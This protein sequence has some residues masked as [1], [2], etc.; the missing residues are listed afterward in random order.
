MSGQL[1]C[2][3]MGWCFDGNNGPYCLKLQGLAMAWTR[4]TNGMT[5]VWH[6]PPATSTVGIHI[7]TPSMTQKTGT[8][9]HCQQYG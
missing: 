7:R 8:H 3:A 2:D 4:W 6:T 5:S 1:Y 9:K